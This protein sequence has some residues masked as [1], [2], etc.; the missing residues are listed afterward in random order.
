MDI[1]DRLISRLT[2][3]G[4]VASLKRIRQQLSDAEKDAHLVC[5][6]ATRLRFPPCKALC[7]IHASIKRKKTKVI[8]V[9]RKK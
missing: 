2:K 5:Q 9:L 7:A 3:D 6:A 4:Q 8:K 1:S